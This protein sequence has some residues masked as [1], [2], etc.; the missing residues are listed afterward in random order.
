MPKEKTCFFGGKAKE[1]LENSIHVH[2]RFL[3]VEWHDT[4]HWT[5]VTWIQRLQQETIDTIFG[6]WDGSDAQ[7]IRN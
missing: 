7:I 3:M 6:R 4:G 2:F 5:K 1:K